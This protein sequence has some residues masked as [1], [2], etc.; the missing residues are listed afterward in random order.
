MQFRLVTLPTFWGS[1]WF[2][3]MA[4]KLLSVMNAMLEMEH[5]YGQANLSLSATECK[6][7]TGS[8]FLTGG[9]IPFL[10]KR[11]MSTSK[12]L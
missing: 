9:H 12:K 3:P 2:I 1:L 8:I 6:Y 10:R 5:E 4:G 7:R 11:G